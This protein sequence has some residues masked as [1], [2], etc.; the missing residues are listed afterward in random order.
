MSGVG[1]RPIRNIYGHLF[2]AEDSGE[3]PGSGGI[4][5]GG[6]TCQRGAHIALRPYA[7]LS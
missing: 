7:V 5:P 6:V 1:D 4:E 3:S 2:L